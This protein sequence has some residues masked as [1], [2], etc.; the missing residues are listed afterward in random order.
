MSAVAT[1]LYRIERM[2]GI[3]SSLDHLLRLE[4]A[5]PPLLRTTK[6]DLTTIRIFERNHDFKQYVGLD[7]TPIEV[8]ISCLCRTQFHAYVELK[9]IPM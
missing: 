2:C 6:S 9:F 3:Y 8:S 1:N 4:I 7:S 5:L